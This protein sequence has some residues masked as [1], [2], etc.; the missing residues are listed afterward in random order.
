MDHMEWC[1]KQ[2]RVSDNS[3]V[4]DNLYSILVA[5]LVAKFKMPDIKRYTGINCS[6]I[7]LRLYSI[8][9]R[10]HGL[11]ELQMITMFPLSLSGAAQRWFTSLESLRRRTWDD[12]AQEFL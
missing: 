7:H 4:W 12:L 2:L 6:H 1:I 8:M 10:A 5:S 3:V 9:M 11:D